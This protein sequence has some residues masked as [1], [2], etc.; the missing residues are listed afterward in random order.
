[1]RY[2]WTP[3]AS[4][5]SIAATLALAGAPPAQAQTATTVSVA[6]KDHRFVPAELTAPAN[7]PV[8]IEVTNQDSTP[9]EFESKSLRVEKVVA[10][11]AK[12]SVQIRA[13]APGRYRFFDDY[14][15]DTTEGFL[16]VQ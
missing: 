14:H 2:L 10:G 5:L 11:G 6:L 15:E 1:M 13:L 3:K 7:K 16:V 8:V 4:V 12:I 9:S